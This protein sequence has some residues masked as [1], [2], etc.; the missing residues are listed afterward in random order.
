MVWRCRTQ[1]DAL[2]A[3]L[4]RLA[5]SCGMLCTDEA[6]IHSMDVTS[7]VVAEQSQLRLSWLLSR[8]SLCEGGSWGMHSREQHVWPDARGQYTS[9]HGQEQ[10]YAWYQAQRLQRVP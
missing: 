5:S 3:E 8:I 2:R 10:R 6:K 9:M 1:D 7:N 4:G